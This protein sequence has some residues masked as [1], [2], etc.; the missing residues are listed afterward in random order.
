MNPPND[1][2]LMKIIIFLSRDDEQSE[3]LGIFLKF[4]FKIVI[5]HLTFRNHGC[6][7]TIMVIAF[8]SPD[9]GHLPP[10]TVM[11]V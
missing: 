4:Q 3:I 2:H 1:R 11:M 8:E 6:Q 9:E 10:Y 7:K 5:V